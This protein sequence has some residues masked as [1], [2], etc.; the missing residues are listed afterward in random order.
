MISVLALN[1][2]PNQTFKV[3]VPGDVRNLNLYLTLSYNTIAG[4]WIMGIYDNSKNPIVLN[5]PLLVGQNL[6]AQ[7]QYLDIGSVYL[8]NTGD[9]AL[10][11]DDVNIGKF[12]LVWKLV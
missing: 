9:A 12:E 7:Y 11:P 3:N 1:N 5:I 2:S 8:I 4:Y 10:I 6:L